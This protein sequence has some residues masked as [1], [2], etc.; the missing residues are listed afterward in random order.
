MVYDPAGGVHIL[1]GG[2]FSET[3]LN[4]TW[5]YNMSENKWTV[6]SPVS[7][8]TDRA[9]YAMAFDTR[10][11]VAVM[12]GGRLDSIS[13]YTE[14]YNPVLDAWT[15]KNPASFPAP[16][17]LHSMAYD[18]GTGR[19]V[20]FGGRYYSSGSNFAYFGDTWTYDHSNNTWTNRTSGSA[21]SPRCGQ[22]MSCDPASGLIV[23]F[24]GMNDTMIFRDTWTYNPSTNKWTYCSPAS[25]PPARSGAAMAADAAGG[26]VILFGGQGQ[27]AMLEDTWSYNVTG[28]IWT[29]KG[30]GNQPWPRWGMAMT[31]DLPSGK[32]FFFGGQ[33]PKG[34]I[35]GDLMDD[36]GSYDPA[37]NNWASWRRR[38][39]ACPR[40]PLSTAREDWEFSSAV[41][42]TNST[43]ET[44]GPTAHLTT[45]GAGC[46]Q[47]L[48]PMAGPMPVCAM[49]ATTGSSCS[50]AA[51]A[52][53]IG[54]SI[55]GH[56]T[57]RT[58]HGQIDSLQPTHRWAAV[59]WL[60]TRAHILS[61]ISVRPM[62]TRH[63]HI[64][65]ARISGQGY[66]LP[67][68]R[69]RGWI[70]PWSTMRAAN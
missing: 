55:P 10:N 42:P 53:P 22:S 23:L 59:A 11:G 52:S 61:S 19:T 51:L 13:S 64:M 69:P 45:G 16:R 34:D 68:F 54:S 49:T 67:W 9:G 57:S 41:P 15:N 50:S 12:F 58:V 5:T 30:L 24:G 48:L 43:S 7:I 26:A 18:P 47:R 28:N 25:S 31:C 66:F 2:I 6:R 17:G 32:L 46:I 33:L 38:R 56:I 44:P 1:F 40:G 8:Q 65:R 35:H 62:A 60:M 39:L 21:P 14:T 4:D 20:L 3:N 70:R 36:Y 27:S 29:S 63:G 37:L